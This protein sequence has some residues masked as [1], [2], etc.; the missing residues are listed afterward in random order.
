MGT[1][2]SISSVDN[3]ASQKYNKTNHNTCTTSS[4]TG[5]L[6]SVSK[7]V[8]D[9]SAANAYRRVCC[10]LKVWGQFVSF[11]AVRVPVCPAPPRPQATYHEKYARRKDGRGLGAHNRLV[12][13]M[14]RTHK[15]E[16]HIHSKRRIPL[17]LYEICPSRSSVPNFFT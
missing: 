15:C 3:K 13:Q 4:S 17:D 1:H 11:F 8:D 7:K 12:H 9:K 5:T 2:V 14:E 6:H 10:L 16:N